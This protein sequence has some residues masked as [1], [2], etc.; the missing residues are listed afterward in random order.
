MV[1]GRICVGRQILV[2]LDAVTSSSLGSAKGGAEFRSPL[3]GGSAFDQ[4][5]SMDAPG[6]D[7]AGPLCHRAISTVSDRSRTHEAAE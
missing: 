4:Q 2:S 5:A 3:L 1:A 6:L 7:A